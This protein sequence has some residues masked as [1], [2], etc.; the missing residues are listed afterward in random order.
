M[1]TVF[2]SVCFALSQAKKMFV[3]TLAVLVSSSQDH[4]QDHHHHHHHAR[5]EPHH[6]WCG[7]GDARHGVHAPIVVSGAVRMHNVALPS[8]PVP[9]TEGHHHRRRRLAAVSNAGCAALWNQND[10]GVQNIVANVSNMTTRGMKVHFNW[11]AVD[12][13][14]DYAMCNAS[15]AAAGN[16]V[17]PCT[18]S[19]SG[20]APCPFVCTAAKVATAAKI[21]VAK[22]RVAWLKTYLEEMLIVRSTAS[23]TPTYTAPMRSDQTGS[24]TIAD[25]DLV[26]VMT[27][28][29][30][31][32]S[33]IAGYASCVQED[34]CGR[35]VVGHF[36][37]CPDVI[38]PSKALANDQ[39]A[40]ER[41]TALHEV[42]HILGG[43]TVAR[44]FRNASTGH[45]LPTAHIV[46][47][48]NAS[49]N[50]WNGAPRNVRSI[51]TPRALAVYREQSGCA[52]LQ[53]I[54]IED[55][56][57]GVNAHWEARVLGAEVMSYGTATGEVYL[58][59]ITLAF[60]EDTG[61]YKGNYAICGDLA[62]IDTSPPS[63]KASFLASGSQV[64]TSEPAPRARSAGYLRWGRDE[65]CD[66]FTKTPDVW[67]ERYI[68]E[69][70][71]S[72]G[73]TSDNRLSS[74]CSQYTYG[75]AKDGPTAF[76]WAY[77]VVSDPPGGSEAETF[78]RQT[79]ARTY[80]GQVL[81][82]PPLYTYAKGAGFSSA[83]DY[84][85][86]AS[87]YWNC[88]HKKPESSE[89][90]LSLGS[91][92]NSTGEAATDFTGVF[93]ALKADVEKFS[94][95][96]YCPECRCFQSSLREWYKAIDVTFSS[97]GLCYRSNCFRE[98]YLQFAMEGVGGTAWF[99]CPKEGGRLFVPGFTGA[100]FCP[101]AKD[102]CKFETITG[103]LYAET[104]LLSVWLWWSFFFIAPIIASLLLCVCCHLKN[105]RHCCIHPDALK[106]TAATVDEMEGEVVRSVLERK[107]DFAR[108]KSIA[109]ASSASE[110]ERQAAAKARTTAF[111][112]DAEARAMREAEI[113]TEL[114]T[115][116]SEIAASMPNA[117]ALREAWIATRVEDDD[118]TAEDAGAR[119]DEAVESGDISGLP[120][121]KKAKE[122]VDVQVKLAELE[123]QQT[124]LQDEA[125]A[126]LDADEK[127]NVA[128][129]E[130][131]KADEVASKAD[132]DAAAKAAEE[133][134]KGTVPKVESK[135]GGNSDAPPAEA[136]AP[137]MDIAVVEKEL[138]ALIASLKS[139]KAKGKVSIAKWKEVNLAR[140]THLRKLKRMLAAAAA[141][142][143]H[144]QCEDSED[145]AI[146]E[147]SKKVK[148]RGT[149]WWMCALDVPCC[150]MCRYQCNDKWCWWPYTRITGLLY[151]CCGLEDP[152]QSD[153]KKRI[154][155]LETLS[156]LD[157]DQISL[158][159]RAV[160][161]DPEWPQRMK[162]SSRQ[163]ASSLCVIAIALH[164]TLPQPYF[165][166]S[167]SLSLSLTHT[168][169][170][171]R[172]RARFPHTLRTSGPL[173]G[174]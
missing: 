105:H 1:A 85:P 76:N 160:K 122:I 31:A 134:E 64:V 59:D 112:A 81:S 51:V 60:L 113:E 104:S 126:L 41:H 138:D 55:Q 94:G 9:A 111:T 115:T 42:I 78:H 101:K 156:Q 52:S 86:V 91:G 152:Q 47:T 24:T 136:E 77:S 10:R 8:P 13:G 23:I 103:K 96:A 167:L 21:A 79:Q 69:G 6:H 147:E 14:S 172:A 40:S 50:S 143:K 20:G 170:H 163:S 53:G 100:L 161:P 135:T 155:H 19:P 32:Q 124:A 151:G 90:T 35:C 2:D 125:A 37:W 28:R 174:F 66:F 133:A 128:E 25:V 65:G 4:H 80:N 110:V 49:R 33:G 89:T 18:T 29:S 131:V 72:Y 141:A 93:S 43:M 30:D 36:N 168:H 158:I 7:F 116:E 129:A 38:D 87:G 123:M 15:L 73:C 56:P 127:A 58:G 140:F 118:W 22:K 67:P 154:V 166:L 11:E 95:Q 164:L 109:D 82:L 68:C 149:C 71:T 146:A 173:M 107:A 62:V 145:D 108:A 117:K 106:G 61:Q 70:E 150:V 162:V 48:V 16:A 88:Q 39:I 84:A 98:D 46:T 92:P 83:M 139:A 171:T 17:D 5:D 153:E 121:R 132:V 114:S 137:P 27:M 26:I 45:A 169:T 75:Q 97:Y 159:H 34:E 165:S 148:T 119:I 120:A 3:F 102:F 99:T 74:V 44:Q 130:A 157:I 142:A 54:P 57:T 144:P 12:S 63:N